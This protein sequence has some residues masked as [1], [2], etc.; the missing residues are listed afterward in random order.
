MTILH[1]LFAVTFAALALG[2]LSGL[3][4]VARSAATCPDCSGYTQCAIWQDCRSVL[5][6]VLGALLCCLM[7]R[8]SEDTMAV[9]P[10][11]QRH[12]SEKVQLYAYML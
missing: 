10:N 5:S 7:T 11:F 12:A 9:Q 8:G 6:F 3:G 2:I 4:F 1:S